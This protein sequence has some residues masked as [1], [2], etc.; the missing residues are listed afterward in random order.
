MSDGGPRHGAGWIGR[1]AAPARAF[2]PLIA[3]T[4]PSATPPRCTAA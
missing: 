2:V 3:E 1:K 4:V